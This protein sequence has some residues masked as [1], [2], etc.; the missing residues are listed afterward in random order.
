MLV[1]GEY[2][3]AGAVFHWLDMDGVAVMIVED[4]KHV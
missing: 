4:N 1:V 3:W 2:L